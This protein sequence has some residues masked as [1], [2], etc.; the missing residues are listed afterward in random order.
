MNDN[1]IVMEEVIAQLADDKEMLQTKLEE[2]EIARMEWQGRL[3]ELGSLL[4]VSNEK[5]L[6]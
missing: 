6:V 1:R 5:L 3:D 4:S 2:D